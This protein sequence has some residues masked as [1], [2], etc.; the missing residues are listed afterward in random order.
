MCEWAPNAASVA[1][2]GDFNDWNET[3]HLCTP[4]DYNK[5]R[6]TIPA[7]S[8]GESPI[9]HGTKVK[10]LIK[11]HDGQTLWRMSPWT[12]YA[13]Q[14]QAISM[15]FQPIHW[16][17][18]NGG[19]QWQ[20][21]LP[22]RPKSVRIYEAHVGIS[23]P[24]PKVASYMYFADN[25]LPRIKDLGYTC[26]ELM[27]IM[28]HAYYGSFGYHV[29]NF[30]AVSSR[31]GNPDEF[32]YLV[33]K[34]H[35]LGLTVVLD[36]VHSHAAKNVNDGLN[37]FD[38]T[39]HCFFHSGGKVSVCMCL[40]CTLQWSLYVI[41]SHTYTL[42]PSQGDHSLWDSR[43]FDYTQWETLRFLLSNL[44]WLLDEYKVDGFRYDAV[45]S[46]LYSHR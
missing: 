31:Y 41:V 45:T 24:E 3:S 4:S 19:Y 28:E 9:P 2:V 13:T 14:N 42:T 36:L 12:K 1:V 34:A 8:G 23:S 22:P 27:A 30:F 39:D 26:V 18:P 43:I 40:L 44:R 16:A 10:L 32:K 35:G 20:H 17:P 37:M 25:V 46:M 38:G 11:T 29:T 15:D 6:L 5:F 7:G 21:S 33:D